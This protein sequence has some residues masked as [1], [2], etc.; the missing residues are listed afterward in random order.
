MKRSKNSL[1]KINSLRLIDARLC[2]IYM[3]IGIYTFFPNA[4]TALHVDH[5]KKKLF[6]GQRMRF[7]H[8]DASLECN[9]ILWK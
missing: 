4:S 6:R 9:R 2:A 8:F 5:I 1:T 3:M 7:F